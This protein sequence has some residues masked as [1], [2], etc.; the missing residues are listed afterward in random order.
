VG[1]RKGVLVEKTE[2]VPI[3]QGRHA[4]REIAQELVKG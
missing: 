1:K 4:G 2:R 3:L